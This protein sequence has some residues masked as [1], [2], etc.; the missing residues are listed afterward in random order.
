MR[1][2]YLAGRPCA[3]RTTRLADPALAEANR[4]RRR[5]ARDEVRAGRDDAA[6]RGELPV[7]GELAEQHDREVPLQVRRRVDGEPHTP[8]QH[9]A[10]HLGGQVERAELDVAGAAGRGERA[11]RRLAAVARERKHA[12]DLRV[13]Q[14]GGDLA[15]GER[16]VAEVD[17]HDARLAPGG[18][19]GAREPAAAA[20]G[21]LLARLVVYARR[22][23]AVVGAVVA[24]LVVAAKRVADA[25]ARHAPPGG[26]AGGQLLLADVGE[27][28]EAA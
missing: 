1:A 22:A 21:A 19:D 23:A 12:V 7:A 9:G 25:V 15:L 28:A 26:S 4:L 10:K 17:R 18:A 3:P 11:Q 14:R 20:V 24:G 6:L 8:G 13:A 5:R 16:R 2:G 27:D